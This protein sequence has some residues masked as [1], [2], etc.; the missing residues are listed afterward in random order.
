MSDRIKAADYAR[1]A[2]KRITFDLAFPAKGL[3]QNKSANRYALARLRKAS[4]EEGWGAS[5]DANIADIKGHDRYTVLIEGYRPTGPGRPHDVH[6][7]PAT[8]KGH[9]DGIADALCVDDGR[10]EVDYPSVWAGTVKGGRVTVHVIPRE[11]SE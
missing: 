6:N 11:A 1:K 4:R 9:I 2:V 3:W 10:F 7:M 8:L 5:L